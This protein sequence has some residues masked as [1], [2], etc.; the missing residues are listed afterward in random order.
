M[1]DQNTPAIDEDDDLPGVHL[2]LA[3]TTG[4]GD[5]T[6]TSH[7]LGMRPY[8]LLTGTPEGDINIEGAMLGLNEAA[9]LMAIAVASMVNAEGADPDLKAEVLGLIQD[10]EVTDTSGGEA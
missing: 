4:D 1:T 10:A 9:G 5:V 6:I 7:L 3:N 8:L 2:A